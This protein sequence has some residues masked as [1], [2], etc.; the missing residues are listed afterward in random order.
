MAP[1]HRNIIYIFW[2]IT[3][4]SHSDTC[5]ST[6][7]IHIWVYNYL[8]NFMLKDII[9]IIHKHY[10]SDDWRKTQIYRLK[11]KS[12]LVIDR[13]I[14]KSVVLARRRWLNWH[15]KTNS[16]IVLIKNVL[17]KIYISSTNP[18]LTNHTNP[19]IKKI[20]VILKVR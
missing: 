11:N 20:R 9:M 3:K 17:F 5:L 16:R 8:P 7:R 12:D 6:N 14:M 13:G 2:Y 10:M 15:L 1:K 4:F 18:L 19:R